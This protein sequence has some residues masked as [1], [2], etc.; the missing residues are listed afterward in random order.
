MYPQ[1]QTA[2]YWGR[3]RRGAEEERDEREEGEEGEEEVGGS[4]L[5]SGDT[6]AA[7]LRGLAEAAEMYSS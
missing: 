1:P 2:R 4:L 5:P 6:V 3:V 7:V